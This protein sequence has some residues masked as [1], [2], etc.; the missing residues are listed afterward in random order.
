MARTMRFEATHQV[1][2]HLEARV[3]QGVRESQGHWMEISDHDDG[4]ITARFGADGLGWATGWVLS[5]GP[6]ARVLEPPELIARVRE[7]AEGALRQYEPAQP[8][9]DAPTRPETRL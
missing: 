1:A 5:L 7:A 6:A 9:I 2:V 4:S 3:A 8:A